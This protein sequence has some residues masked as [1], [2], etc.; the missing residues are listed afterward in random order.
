MQKG[1]V[2]VEERAIGLDEFDDIQIEILPGQ[3]WLHCGDLVFLR[4]KAPVF[5][6]PGVPRPE[7]FRGIC[8][9]ARHA[10]VA[11]RKTLDEQDA[12]G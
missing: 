1:L 9:K 11:I 10:T 8:L 2:P 6:L 12:K 7:V 5:R 3:E 4:D